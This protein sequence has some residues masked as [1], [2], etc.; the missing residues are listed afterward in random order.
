MPQADPTLRRQR[1][2]LHFDALVGLVRRRF[3]ELPEQRRD[4]DF[5]L[6]DTLMAG[7]ALFSLK[8]PSLLAFMHRA[9]D[10]NL[11]RV[12]GLQAVPSDTQM[13]TI[14][15]DVDPQRLRPVFRDVFRQLQRGK[16]LEPYVFLEGC[17]LVALDGV[18]YFRSHKVHCEHCLS[19]QHKT[20]AVSYYHQM[21][22][23]VL[24][25]PDF[26][27]VIPL[28]PEPIQRRDGQDK[29]DCER[30][31]ARRW[32]RQ[33]RKDHP[34]LPIIVTEDALG[35]NAPHIRD[36]L[37]NHT[38][39]ILGVKEADHQHLFEQ[40]QRRLEAGQVE[41]VHEE[42]A[43]SGAGRSWRFVNGV[44]INESNQEVIVN[45]LVYVEVDAGGE[46]HSW[47]WV[48]DL[49]LARD[50]VRQV[51]RGGR[52]RWRIE[53]ET[54]NTLKNQ[55]YHFEHNYGHGSKHLAVVFALLMMLAFLIDQVQ[56][57]CNPLFQR[58]WQ[59]QGAKCALWEAV[60]HLF[61]SFEVSSMS[62]IYKGIA[63]GYKRPTLKALIEPASAGSR[64]DTS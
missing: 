39:F 37:D 55:G 18:E 30:N 46:V 50:N 12:F 22:A 26:P 48:T 7:L 40:Y 60:R 2:H 27:E 6:A 56:Q 44:S 34:H 20:G 3:E 25:H 1:R 42:D 33:F 17:Y 32:L 41:A 54:F 19:C 63:F 36:L 8:D 47:A 28:A 31:A 62:E 58:A 45:L 11:R 23:A 16:V 51:A 35:S 38:H 59:K 53:N 49:T 24:V 13:R 43:S 5:S 14:L 29:N 15:D 52:T 21:L 4:P 10:H 9:V 57:R 64:T 61:A